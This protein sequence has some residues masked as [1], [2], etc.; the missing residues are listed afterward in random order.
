MVAWSVMKNVK[1]R[2]DQKYISTRFVVS[3]A[4]SQWFDY[5]R[6]KIPA[7]VMHEV[8]KKIISKQ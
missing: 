1:E 5:L 2:R 4:E 8:R 3:C 6:P 7:K